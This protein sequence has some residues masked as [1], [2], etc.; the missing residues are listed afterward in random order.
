MKVQG[1]FATTIT[2]GLMMSTF[3]IAGW[4]RGDRSRGAEWNP[5]RA[6]SQNLPSPRYRSFDDHDRSWISRQKVGD[7]GGYDARQEQ[8]RFQRN[9]ERFDRYYDDQARARQNR[10]GHT[11]MGTLLR[12]DGHHYFLNTVRGDRVR[13]HVDD[14]TLLDA[15]IER[16]DLVIAKMKPNGHAIALR[17]DRGQRGGPYTRSRN[18]ENRHGRGR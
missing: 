16:G 3:A 14:R 9:L 7:T 11:V 15:G 5:D 6:I 4:D 2:I 18:Y 1:I 17:K 12:Q 8:R 10:M 13:L